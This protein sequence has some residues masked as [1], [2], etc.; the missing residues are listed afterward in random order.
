MGSAGEFVDVD[1]MTGGAFALSGIVLRGD[2]R[3]DSLSAADPIALTPAQ[4]LRVYRPGTRLSYAY[5][6]YN[7]S[8]QVEVAA[9]IHRG[10]ERVFATAPNTLVLPPGNDRRFAAAGGL[11]LG[12]GLPPGNYRLV[13]SATT[14]DANRKG[15]TRAAVQQIGFDVEAAK[16]R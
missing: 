9:S 5:E 6:I 16:P 13:V 8:A 14:P 11:S 4:S 10:T 3:Q 2:D 15:R 12:E 7:A 1:D